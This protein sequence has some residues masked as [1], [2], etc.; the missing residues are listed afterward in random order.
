M[1]YVKTLAFRL[2]SRVDPR[3][4]SGALFTAATLGTEAGDR[5]TA[6]ELVNVY[7]EARVAVFS[8][9]ERVLAPERMSLELSGTVLYKTDLT[10]SSGV[11]SKP[12]GYFKCISLTTNALVRIMVVPPAAMNRVTSLDSATAPIVTEYANQFVAVSSTNVPNAA[13]YRLR[14]HGITPFTTSDILTAA[15]TVE[16]ID[17]RWH[18]LLIELG[19]AI[20]N[21]MGNAEVVALGMKMAGGGE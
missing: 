14:Y 12:D 21:G 19:V 8:A 6:Q 18:P 4:K 11:A 7:N 13:N 10:F 1:A 3:A 2:A 20:A 9:L 15:T 5:F 17:D 16:T